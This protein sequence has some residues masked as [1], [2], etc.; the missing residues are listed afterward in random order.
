MM[1]DRILDDKEGDSDND[2]RLFLHWR[3][4]YEGEAGMLYGYNPGGI[5]CNGRQCKEDM[6]PKG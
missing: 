3:A 1:H 4:Q 2:H 6:I 5:H